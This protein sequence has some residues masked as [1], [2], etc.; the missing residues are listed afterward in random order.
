MSDSP[1]RSPRRLHLPRFFRELGPGLIT[2]AADD[3]PS[4]ISTYS[5]AGATHGYSILWMV[6]FVIP[7]V[8]AVQVMC[9]R[10]GLVTGRGLASN[11]RHR[12]PRWVLWL[13]CAL[14]VVAN[15]VNIGADL[16][17]MAAAMEMTTGWSARF[18]MP[19][20]AVGLL[21]LLFFSS[22][23]RIAQVFKWLTMVLLA[24]VVT[25]FLA[26]PDWLGVL[27]GTL[28]PHV[29]LDRTFLA[30]F[31][32][33]I[34]TTI[35]PY[36][37][38]WQAAE[39]V[40]E[41]RAMGRGTEEERAGATLQELGAAQR[42]V[43]SGMGY[44]AMIMYFIVLT[45]ASTLHATGRTDIATAR[46]AAEALRPLAGDAAAWCFTL[47]LVGTGMLGVPVLAGSAAYA[48]CEAERWRGSL[49][50]SPRVAPRF[51]AVLAAAVLL[52]AGLV[53]SGVDPVR[54]LFGAAVVNGLLA[55]PLIALVVRLTSD[56]AVM[57]EHASPP[58]MRRLGWLAFAAM[59]LAGSALIA[60][61]A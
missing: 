6:P 43:A 2:G 56:P 19:I 14:L 37:F 36:L 61:P 4:G 8:V 49:D 16:S 10:L 46:D 42:D 21:L 13:A 27:E 45:T 1:A 28:V 57:G 54:A 51:Y 52:G 41:E 12:Y 20:I 5:V 53:V 22:Y 32:A 29:R 26:R 39:E 44:A 9:A 50:D 25:A 11:I 38:F 55:P 59:A 7:L 35:S 31:V 48:V 15:V 23:K 33:V 58:W 60:A 3:D 30:T 47:G 17:G 40:E 24:Y 18:W 34:G